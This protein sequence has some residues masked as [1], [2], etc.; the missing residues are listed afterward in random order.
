[1][2]KIKQQTIYPT[3]FYHTQPIDLSNPNYRFISM[4]RFTKL[5]CPFY[6]PMVPD[7]ICRLC[8]YNSSEHRKYYI[9]SNYA[10]KIQLVFFKYRFKKFY[11]ENFNKFSQLGR[12]HLPHPA[13]VI[14]YKIKY[15]R[16]W[17]IWTL[18]KFINSNLH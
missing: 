3:D 4:Y 5:G 13:A 10:R 8:N 1:M 6:A 9:Y 11:R 7:G 12:I 17:S 14:K 2:N 15:Y 16:Q 18:D